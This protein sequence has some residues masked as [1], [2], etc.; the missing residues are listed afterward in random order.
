VDYEL[1]P[2]MDTPQRALR[3]DAP[4]I[5]ESGNL[6][7][8]IKVRRGDIEAGFAQA[9]VIVERTFHTAFTEHAFLEPECCIARVTDQGRIEVYVGSQIP[10]QDRTQIAACLDVPEAQVRVIGTL[11]GG[12]FGG[13]EDIMGQIHAALL[14]KLTGRPSDSLLRHGASHILSGTPRFASKSAPGAMAV[15]WHR[16]GAMGDTGAYASLGEV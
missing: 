2:V 6:L 16:S 11:I 15:W 7:K 5:H 10:Y 14:A 9:D 12:G 8:H 13:K 4:K 1:L 3:P